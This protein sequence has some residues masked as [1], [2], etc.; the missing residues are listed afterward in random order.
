[1]ADI[2]VNEY[3]SRISIETSIV[4]NPL[5]NASGRNVNRALQLLKQNTGSVEIDKVNLVQITIGLP[6]C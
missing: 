6:I 3:H 2:F 1:M 4:D 5:T